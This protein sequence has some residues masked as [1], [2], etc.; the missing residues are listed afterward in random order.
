M[1]S[2]GKLARHEELMRR[3]HAR[4]DAL[5]ELLGGEN[6]LRAHALMDSQ[7]ALADLVSDRFMGLLR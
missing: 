4:A 5:W 3:I 6:G 1:K 7:L 2:R